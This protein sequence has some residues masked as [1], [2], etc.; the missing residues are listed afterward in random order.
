MHSGSDDVGRAAA[1]PA[2]VTLFQKRRKTG[3][4]ELPPLTFHRLRHCHASLLIASGADIAVA[5]KLLGHASIAITADA[6]G[7]L[8]GTVTSDEVNGAA[9]LMAHGA[10]T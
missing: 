3:A 7:H 9:N 10:H 6:Y 4:D 8:I 2:Y 1:R 5:G